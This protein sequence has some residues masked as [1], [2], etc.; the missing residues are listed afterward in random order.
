MQINRIWTENEIIKRC[1]SN[2]MLHIK[3]IKILKKPYK[4]Y[5]AFDKYLFKFNS[6]EQ[7]ATTLY[8]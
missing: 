8:C 1:N 5:K 6:F 3:L 4:N 2:I 7:I